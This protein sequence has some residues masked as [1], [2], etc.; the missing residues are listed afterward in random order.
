MA[1]ARIGQRTPRG[2]PSAG[3]AGGRNAGKR[4]D[5][6]ATRQK[7]L[8]ALRRL[9][10][11]GHTQVTLQTVAEEAS[12]S[13]ATAYRYFGSVEDAVLAYILEF[14]DQ[15]AAAF[16]ERSHGES[17]VARFELWCRTWVELVD[18]G[19]G[20][21]LIYLRSPEGF[22]ARRAQGEAVISA[23]CRHL[24]PLM[25]EALEEL[26]ASADT[27]DVALFVWNAIYDPREILDLRRTLRW[28]RARIEQGL[29]AM[30][31]GSLREY[32]RAG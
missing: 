7:L 9:L 12:V 32:D 25:G 8:V 30:F 2:A 27:L 4:V 21:S 13:T 14:P 19:W 10:D 24:E 31:L 22:L 20:T 5:S 17:G 15:V 18:E 16:A 1:E 23:V 29:W 26:G 11:H 3:G 28:T 6:R